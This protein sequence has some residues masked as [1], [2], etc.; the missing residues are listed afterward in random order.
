MD[1]LRIASGV[2]VRFQ[3]SYAI[4]SDGGGC[5]GPTTTRIPKDSAARELLS[6]RR[7][8]PGGYCCGRRYQRCLIFKV[9]C[10]IVFQRILGVH[11]VFQNVLGAPQY[12]SGCSGHRKP[13]SVLSQVLLREEVPTPPQ[14]RRAHIASHNR[15]FGRE[16]CATSGRSEES[17]AML[18]PGK[19]PR[20]FGRISSVHVG[21][22]DCLLRT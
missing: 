20:D 16:D 7:T 22:S 9:R 17:V 6:A 2:V 19:A 1:V 10:V 12:I 4:R 11:S 13:R 15:T 3:E 21:R 8:A 14:A 5:G 18:L